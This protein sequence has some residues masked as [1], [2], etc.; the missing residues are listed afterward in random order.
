MKLWGSRKAN[1]Q[2]GGR[3]AV[4]WKLKDRQP[5]LDALEQLSGR[6]AN[7]KN[8]IVARHRDRMLIALPPGHLSVNQ[9]SLQGEVSALAEAV[10][11]GTPLTPTIVLRAGPGQLLDAAESSLLKDAESGR[12]DCF[13]I[14][15]HRVLLATAAG[16]LTVF[17]NDQVT[18][19]EPKQEVVKRH[20]ENAHERR[21]KRDGSPSEP[22][23]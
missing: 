16:T 20:A 15:G 2:V 22:V 17:Q 8:V 14:F 5:L 21:N 1:L 19:S 11:E 12:V 9:E 13:M 4:E 7:A 23:K 3:K 18:S 10:G 6:A